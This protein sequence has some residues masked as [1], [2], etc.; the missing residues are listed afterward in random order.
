MSKKARSGER[1][2]Y[3]LLRSDGP[4]SSRGHDVS[5]ERRDDRLSDGGRNRA[6]NAG[7]S[8]SLGGRSRP[9][10]EAADDDRRI[11]SPNDKSRRVATTAAADCG[12]MPNAGTS[13]ESLSSL[14]ATVACSCRDTR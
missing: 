2:S 3:F 8:R 6:S 7:T 13:H 5:A 14:L 12:A 9:L 10:D 1:A 11:V 4:R